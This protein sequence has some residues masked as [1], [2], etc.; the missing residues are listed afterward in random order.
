MLGEPVGEA[1]QADGVV[2]VTESL[3]L[4]VA[5]GDVAQVR[6]VRHLWSAFPPGRLR[7]AG[8]RPGA[9]ARRGDEAA[10]VR[11]RTLLKNKSSHIVE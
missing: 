10:R 9:R 7:H 6:T 8:T 11:H 5:Q 1:A 2:P 3:G 4:T